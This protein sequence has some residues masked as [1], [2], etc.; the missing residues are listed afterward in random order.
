MN[1]ECSM[2]I[3]KSENYRYTLVDILKVFCAC[4]VVFIHVCEIQDGH[5][6]AKLILA[7]FSKQAVPFFF[8][9]SGFFVGRKFNANRAN[10]QSVYR[11][12][13]NLFL[14]YLV[15]CILWLPDM[16]TAY[17][18]MYYNQSY[19]YLFF[20]LVR[21]IFCA[22]YSAYWYL[23][24]LA[25]TTIIASI[26]LGHQK[27]KILY[28]FAVIGL[29]WG[30]IYELNINNGIL[31]LANRTVYLF[32][33]WSNNVLMK[34]LPYVTIGIFF[35]RHTEVHQ[36]FSKKILLITY[37]LTSLCCIGLYCFA[38]EVAV[39]FSPLQAILL[40]FISVQPITLNLNKNVSHFCRNISSSLY[41]IHTVI[42]YEIVDKIW[43]ISSPILFRYVMTIG[44][45]LIVYY[46]VKK[47]HLKPLYWMLS[48]K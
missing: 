48:I 10:K 20:V 22:G 21:R 14:L 37:V 34:G 47:S 40:F 25:E 23:L 2:E 27:E 5:E 38:G 12:A 7:C 35:S 19:V 13:G 42:I 36:M 44:L 6:V 16:I 26:F 29:I 28:I 11:Y 18:K 8:I 46:F 43:S 1:T 4:L 45:S 39:L 41:L 17:R 31:A 24:V 15:W 33:S 9:V 30:L 32:F 3:V